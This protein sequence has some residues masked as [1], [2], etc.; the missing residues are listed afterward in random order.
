MA[1]MLRKCTNSLR[2]DELGVNAWCTDVPEPGLVWMRLTRSML[3][4]LTVERHEGFFFSCNISDGCWW[5]DIEL[6]IPIRKRPKRAIS[7]SFER[8]MFEIAE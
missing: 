3:L 7:F 6:M 8:L 5:S 1:E 4:L 2:C